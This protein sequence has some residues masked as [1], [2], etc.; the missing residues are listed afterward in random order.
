MIRGITWTHI[1]QFRIIQVL[2]RSPIPQNIIWSGTFF[3]CFLQQIG[4]SFIW[5]SKVDKKRYYCPNM[6]ILCY[7][8]DLDAE[9]KDH[10]MNDVQINH[11]S[12]LKIDKNLVPVDLRLHGYLS[13]LAKVH[14]NLIIYR[15]QLI[16]KPY[17]IFEN[18]N[19]IVWAVFFY[20]F[21]YITLKLLF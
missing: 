20:C 18:K 8:A 11:S 12:T 1:N 9:D 4:S 7:Q 19:S 15:Q 2:Q 13:N 14:K 21:L 5:F 3:Y 6:N 16:H 10:K 17:F